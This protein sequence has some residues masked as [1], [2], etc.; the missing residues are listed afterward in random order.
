MHP[1]TT[2]FRAVCAALATRAGDPV[3]REHGQA[4]TEYVLVLLGVASIALVVATW[5]A[6]TGM[7][8]ELL[9]RVFQSISSQI[10]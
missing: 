4:T 9:D 10:T 3:R 8:G 2:S 1:F 5:A 6:R 7:I